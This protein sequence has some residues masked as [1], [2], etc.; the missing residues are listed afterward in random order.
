MKKIFC[1][2]S[3]ALL[4]IVTPFA[5][6]QTLQLTLDVPE[7]RFFSGTLLPQKYNKLAKSDKEYAW[8]S[9][10]TPGDYQISGN[11][12]ER[13]DGSGMYNWLDFYR[14]DIDNDG[15]CDWY[16]NAGAPLST[17]GDRDSINTIYLGRKDGWLRIGATVPANKPD[18]LGVGNTTEEQKHYMFGEEIGVIHDA[19]EKAN[20]LV[21]VFHDRHVWRGSKPG[22][23]VQVWDA[24][25]K[26]LRML[27][28][29]EP[30]SKAA[31]VYAFF[32]AHGA[33]L[34]AEKNAAPEDT[35]LRFDSDIEAFEMRQACDPD[36]PWY[37]AVSRHLLALCKRK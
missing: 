26:T 7:C 34:P 5:Q 1:H 27:D 19:G 37:G 36:S 10:I 18:E 20:Y 23:L 9:K 35:V 30:K 4:A 3:I 15:Y 14:T 28:K 17:G 8:L 16:L 21:T 13:V 31:E 22:Y 2:S 12:W 24:N 11:G 25:K 29:W 6:G 33:R 32:K